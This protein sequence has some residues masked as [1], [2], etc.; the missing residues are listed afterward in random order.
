MA[1]TLARPAHSDFTLKKSRFIGC[2]QPVAGRSEARAIV[3]G[4]RAEHP[5]AAHVCWA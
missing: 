5:G 1:L 4:L 3:A 2:V